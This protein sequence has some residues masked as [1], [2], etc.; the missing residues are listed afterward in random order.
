MGHLIAVIFFWLV[1]AMF[2]IGLIGC[3]F[4][5]VWTTID[6]LKEILSKDEEPKMAPGAQFVSAD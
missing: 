1:S 6:D 2:A 3:A 5:V 4:V